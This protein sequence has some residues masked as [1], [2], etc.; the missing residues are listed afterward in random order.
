[1]T[2]RPGIPVPPIVLIDPQAMED[3]ARALELLLRNWD[4]IR[5][6]SPDNDNEKRACLGAPSVAPWTWPYSGG[7]SEGKVCLRR[8]IAA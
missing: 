2:L 1:M 5:W 4:G 3:R 7:P 8:M 6:S